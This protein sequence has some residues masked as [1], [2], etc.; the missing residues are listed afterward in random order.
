MKHYS[1]NTVAYISLQPL[2]RFLPIFNVVQ[3]LLSHLL[4][5]SLPHSKKERQTRRVLIFFSQK[6]RILPIIKIEFTFSSPNDE[7]FSLRYTDLC[8]FFLRLGKKKDKE[9]SFTKTYRRKLSYF[10]LYIYETRTCLVFTFVSFRVK[11]RIHTFVYHG[12]Y[13]IIPFVEG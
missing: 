2:Q 10:T 3:P 7:Y 12:K 1:N 13:L 4:F 8:S 5:L 9:N 11:K 6:Q